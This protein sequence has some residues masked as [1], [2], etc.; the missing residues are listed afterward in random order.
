MS[1]NGE[2]LLL[3]AIAA[4]VINDLWKS[5]FYNDAE[6]YILYRDP[7][8]K[9][10]P[11]TEEEIDQ[12]NQEIARVKDELV[13]VIVEDFVDNDIKTIGD[14]TQKYAT[15]REI[16]HKRFGE[17]RRRLWGAI[18]PRFSTE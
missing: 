3:K 2:F 7:Q 18:K 4:E 17:Y 10:N 15:V 8:S 5:E 14:V 1:E 16:C 13:D 6:D 11:K 12:A 9:T